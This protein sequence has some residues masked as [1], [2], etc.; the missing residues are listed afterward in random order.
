MGEFVIRVTE[1]CP[2]S[3][4]VGLIELGGWPWLFGRQKVKLQR[5]S[6]E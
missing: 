6:K 1:W 4:V 3:L 5:N 2:A